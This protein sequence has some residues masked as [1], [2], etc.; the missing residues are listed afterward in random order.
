MEAESL[1]SWK[2]GI[3]RRDVV[4]VDGSGPC[5]GGRYTTGESNDDEYPE[6]AQWH[7]IDPAKTSLCRL[8]PEP[9]NQNGP[10]SKTCPSMLR[11]SFLNQNRN[12][13]KSP[14]VLAR[15]HQ[16]VRTLESLA[17]EV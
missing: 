10:Q 11:G 14:I 5:S 15:P 13:T 8:N 6:N 12:Q 7:N 4:S 9:M 16:F 2:T 17:I 3:N 1:A